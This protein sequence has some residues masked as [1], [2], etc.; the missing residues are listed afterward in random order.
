MY[1]SVCV[2]ISIFIKFYIYKIEKDIFQNQNGT[3][4]DIYY[5]L[6]QNKMKYISIHIP[7]NKIF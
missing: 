7:G 4:T 1:L 3:F 2:Y 6:Y 5:P